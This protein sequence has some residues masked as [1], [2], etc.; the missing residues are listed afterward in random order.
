[1]HSG[2]RA[3]LAQRGKLS[4]ANGV[5]PLRFFL[6]VTLCAVTASLAA[7]GAK[8]G[9]LTDYKQAQEQA[10]SNKK[11]MLLDF[12]GSDWCGWCI[13]LD[14]EVFS[15]PEFQEYASKNLVLVELDFPRRKELSATERS[16]NEQLAEQHR[17]QGFPTIIVL[18]SEGKKIGNLTYEDAVPEDSRVPL[19]TPAAFIASLEK[20]RKG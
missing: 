20:L 4:Q 5:K 15:K 11:L 17:I 12:T 2:R 7:A 8:P 6:V 3:R 16:Q 19:A 1:M 13:K 10:K 14:K 9:W 18:N